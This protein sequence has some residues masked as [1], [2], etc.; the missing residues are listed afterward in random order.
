MKNGKKYKFKTDLV[1]KRKSI[2]NFR[3]Y[4]LT[5]TNSSTIYFKYEEYIDLAYFN[6]KTQNN[7]RDNVSDD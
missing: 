6:A 5:R 4:L 3:N 7:R 1:L 2:E